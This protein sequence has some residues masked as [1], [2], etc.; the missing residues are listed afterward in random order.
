MLLAAGGR[1]V[2]KGKESRIKV[3]DEKLDVCVQAGKQRW[4]NVMYEINSRI[5][6]GLWVWVWCCGAS[7]KSGEL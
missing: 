3:D 5:I 1:P 7:V 6:S 2:G 4:Q